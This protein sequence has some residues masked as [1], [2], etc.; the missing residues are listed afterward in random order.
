MPADRAVPIPDGVDPVVA[1]AVLLQGITAHYLCTSTYPVAEGDVVVIHAAAGGVGLLLT[2]L[3]ARRGGVVIATTSGGDKHDLAAAAGATHV[4]DYESF[5]D[6]ALEVTHGDGVPVVYDGVGASTF[7][8]SLRALRR[9]G[10]LVLYGG[11]R[12]DRSRPSTRSG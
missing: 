5:V 3:V 4:T 6:V 2:Q 12:A 10:M 1:A 11:A 9:R 8:D 7:D